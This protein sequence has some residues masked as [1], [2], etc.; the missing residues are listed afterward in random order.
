MG[1]KSTGPDYNYSEVNPHSLCG[2]DARPSASAVF[3]YR[4]VPT[5]FTTASVDVVSSVASLHILTAYTSCIFF[6]SV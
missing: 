3:L 5:V 2:M 1:I 4:S 6:V